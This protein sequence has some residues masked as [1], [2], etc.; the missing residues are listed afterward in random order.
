MRH[1]PGKYF[2]MGLVYAAKGA[3]AVFSR[4]NK[5]RPTPGFIPAWSDKP[6]QKSWEKTSP[7]LGVPRVTDSLCPSCVPEIR[8]QILNG[9]L[10]VEVLKDERIGEIKA[11]IIERD[12]KIWMIKECPKHGV[13]EDVMSTDPDMF[14]HLEEMFPGRDQRSHNDETLHDHGGAVVAILHEYQ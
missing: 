4:L 2:E 6:L 11:E 13:F 9:E 10:P 12:G 14:R 7:T 1:R 8:A 5:I 3:W